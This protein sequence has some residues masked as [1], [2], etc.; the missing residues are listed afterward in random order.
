MA[1]TIRAVE[2]LTDKAMEQESDAVAGVVED[3][4][5]EAPS[6]VVAEE[7]NASPSE[8][9]AATENDDGR[10]AT[11]QGGEDRSEQAEGSPGEEAA[12]A[13][14]AKRKKSYRPSLEVVE[15]KVDLFYDKAVFKRG[16]QVGTTRIPYLDQV[17]GNWY[18]VPGIIELR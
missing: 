14:S 7:T 12:A 1:L 2:C 3:G 4:A 9:T 5:T 13:R 11:E 17:P 8:T 15:V 10:N 6:Q 16:L 18:Q